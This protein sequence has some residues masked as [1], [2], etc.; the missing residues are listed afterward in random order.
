MSTGFLNQSDL[1]RL[2]NVTQN[3][4]IRLPKDLM[5]AG[6]REYFQ[7]DSLYHYVKD[8]W[9]FP[10][11][12]NHT[13]LPIE[14]GLED[15]LTTR[16]Y[17]SEA[18]RHDVAYF[19]NILV[20]HSSARHVPI[21]LN[22]NKWLVS[23]NTIKYTDGYGNQSLV[24]TPSH[25]TMSGAWE[26]TL[27]IEVSSRGLRERDDLVELISIFLTDIYY[28]EFYKSGLS[29]KPYGINVGSPSE[30][31]DRNNK[32]FR[33]AVNVDIRTE[34]HREIPIYNIVDKINFCVDLGNIEPDE[35]LIAPNLTINTS[36]DLLTILENL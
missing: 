34:W 33:Q 35:P 11:V 4:I 9:G 27:S 29:I 17:I 28:D 21:S 23:Y 12:V 22:R 36:L 32:I 8:E 30:S 1:L 20:K 2:F 25:F 5:I 6:L 26:G 24:Q 10:K 18:W 3:S 31:D 19:P 16:V 14:A 15:D 7:K 13:D